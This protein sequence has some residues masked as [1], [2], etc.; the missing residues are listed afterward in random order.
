MPARGTA[1]N[2]HRNDF[3][4]QARAVARVAARAVAVWAAAKAANEGVVARG[5]LARTVAPVAAVARAAA[6]AAPRRRWRG[7]R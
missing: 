4:C 5:E 3:D 7:R 2:G 6:R 1:G